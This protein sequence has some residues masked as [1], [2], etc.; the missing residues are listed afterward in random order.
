MDGAR[1]D[2]LTRALSRRT[3]RRAAALGGLAAALAGLGGRLAVQDATPTAATPGATPGASPAAS[4]LASP[5]PLDLLGGTP[6]AA[7][8]ALGRLGAEGCQG[9][10][11]PCASAADCCDPRAYCSV[12]GQ[13]AAL[14]CQDGSSSGSGSKK[15]RDLVP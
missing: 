12:Y 7:G 10:G 3:G 14:V 8:G 5:G 6:A 9:F 4:P 2:A 13:G 15:S 11:G 1:F